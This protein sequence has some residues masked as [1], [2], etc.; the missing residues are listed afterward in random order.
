MD[1]HSLLKEMV[2]KRSYLRLLICL[3]LAELFLIAPL[4]FSPWATTFTI[5][6]NTA[7]ELIVLI[8]FPLWIIH[9]LESRD[10][11][12]LKSSLSLPILVFFLIILISLSQSSSLYDSFKDLA[13][14]STYMV[15]YFMVISMIREKK[16]TYVILGAV[17][18]AG[19][20]AAAYCMFQF[21]AIDFPFWQ[22]L[23]G[24]PR[25][26]STF[27]S[28]NYLAGY[29]AACLPV[30]FVLFTL[31]ENR[32]KKVLFVGL[33]AVLYTAL[34]MTS[35]RA[36][37]LG[38]SLSVIFVLILLLIY[39]GRGFFQQNRAW[40]L[41]LALIIV[42]ISAVYLTPNPLNPERKETLAQRTARVSLEESGLAARFLYWFSALE[43]IR[44]HPFLGLGI[45]TFGVHYPEYQG[46]VLAQEGKGKYIRFAAKSIN[47][48]NDYLHMGAEIGIIGLIAL[49]WLILTYYQ[50]GFAWIKKR[51]GKERLLVIGLMGGATV[52][53]THA[54]L[55]FPFHIIQNGLLFWGILALST[56][57]GEGRMSDDYKETNGTISNP[58][59]QDAKLPGFSHNKYSYLVLRRALEI[60][61][62]CL[63]I[64]LGILRV[65]LFVADTHLKMGKMFMEA[66]IY[67]AAA[68]ELEKAAAID[69]HSGLAYAGLG[70]TH[71]HLA[72]Y[73]EALSSFE[74]A[75]K[76]WIYSGLY[77]DCAY[78]YLKIGEL[79]KAKKNLK[80]NIYLFPNSYG[81][82]FNLADIILSEAEKELSQGKTESAKKRLD[83]DFICYEQGMVFHPNFLP[84]PRLAQAYDKIG[85]D[86]SEERERS[87]FFSF[88]SRG[89]RPIVDFPPPMAKSG[90]PIYF[91]IFLYHPEKFDSFFK[92]SL[93][94][95][96]QWERLIK[97]LAIK[98]ENTSSNN[99]GLLSVL[100]KEG[101]PAGNYT[102]IVRVRYARGK[103]A[104]RKKNF[105][106]GRS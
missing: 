85:I 76:N 101:I 9:L 97:T 79:Q 1:L 16:W 11:R 92:G 62:I 47:A 69:P 5:T 21:Y 95:R 91:K 25:L 40:L 58:G 98:K 3:G 4:V 55:S 105:S 67:P 24:R 94:I 54:L 106:V 71:N 56:S 14:W 102:A 10:Y 63:A 100:W 22:K 90:E 30:A 33:M 49:F 12:S 8:I 84:P 66:G 32:R 42:I 103:I 7:A 15:A 51:K 82:Y 77:N 89:R 86:R 19:F 48:H 53:L 93:E 44:K 34:L 28:T 37:F 65:R 64:Y 13:R 88:F 80:K 17:L 18:F 38:L 68:R 70:I 72:K 6:K 39:Q 26:F 36:A 96:D 43:M 41:R 35:T 99:P 61:T 2:V 73:E 29:L 75:E 31:V 20:L 27:G 50:K 81:A 78:S 83:E 59:K 87:F 52:L 46:K 57:I 45:G 23:S 74:R 104:W 60:G